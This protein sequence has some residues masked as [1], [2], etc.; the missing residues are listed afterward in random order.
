MP[1]IV[2]EVKRYQ[3]EIVRLTSAHRM[4]SESKTET[5]PYSTLAFLRVRAD[6]LEWAYS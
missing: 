2:C 1:E 4:D 6:R 5:G 3:L